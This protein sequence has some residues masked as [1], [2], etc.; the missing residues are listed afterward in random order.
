[1][2][3]IIAA[4]LIISV[5][6]S[7]E[8]QKKKD[9]NKFIF[10]P[11]SITL[12]VGE[13]AKVKI[14]LV[15][16]KGNPVNQV[17]S[18][19]GQRKALDVS[20]R[21]SDSTGVAETTIKAYGPGDLKLRAY[22][23]LK[24]G[25]I[26]GTMKVNVPLPPLE[27]ITFIDPVKNVF[28]GTSVNYVAEVYDKAKLLRENLDITFTS[29]R[30]K[31]AEFDRFGNLTIKKPGKIKITVSV[32]NLK[33][34]VVVSVNANP[35]KKL[36]LTTPS[37]EIRTGDVI[38]L[39]TELLDKNNKMLKNIPI[40]YSYSGKANFSTKNYVNNQSSESVGLPASGL[41][42][43]EGKFVAETPGIYTLTAQSSGFSATQQVKVVPRNVG[44]RL[45]LVGHGTVSNVATCELWVWPG[46]GKH[47]GKDFAV[48]GTHSADGEAYF[49]DVSDPANMK[50][51]DTVKV[52]AR[53]VNDVKISENGKVGIIT[54]EGASN[55]KNG[56]VILDVSDPYNVSITKMYNE[57][58]TGGVHNAFIYKDHVYALSAGTRY[59]VIDISDPKKPF[60]VG[61]Y[62]LDTPGHSI[63]DVWI[64]DGIAYSSNWADGV[65]VVDVGGL[66]QN[67]KS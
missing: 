15:D 12:K 63:H 40:N 9:Q 54:R 58:L 23:R 8:E 43:K 31:I 34:S 52:D 26:M 10:I 38:Q 51:I 66:K 55:R 57:N 14:S 3:K 13:E 65:H 28:V 53:T 49:W 44:K 59:D 45:E 60:T 47:K 48:T 56:L 4:L 67:E 1:M 6:F 20:V 46:I 32:E 64:E 30:K 22:A 16:S 18:I 50:I 19:R 61:S 27:K 33:E 62:E 7:Q 39:T 42:T 37:S 41:I 5:G 21:V 2:K 25:R 24:K 36:N 11:D 35:V 17:F 29:N